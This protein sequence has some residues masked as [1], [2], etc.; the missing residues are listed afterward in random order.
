MIRKSGRTLRGLGHRMGHYSVAQSHA[1]WS[2]WSRPGVHSLQLTRAC[3]EAS[4]CKMGVLTIRAVGRLN[5]ECGRYAWRMSSQGIWA[6]SSMRGSRE[7]R[8]L[9]GRD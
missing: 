2:P 4:I 7:R 8:V 3:P 9:G 6:V 1:A 5:E